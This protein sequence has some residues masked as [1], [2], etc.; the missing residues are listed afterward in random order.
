MPTARPGQTNLFLLVGGL[1]IL[2]LI[3]WRPASGVALL[4]AL[5]VAGLALAL[6]HDYWAIALPGWHPAR[7]AGLVLGCAALGIAAF[8][9]WPIAPIVPTAAVPVLALVLHRQRGRWSNT[10]DRL[11]G[12]PT[13]AA[14]AAR[15]AEELSRGLR[16]GRPA[17]VAVI[18]LDNANDILALHGRD[19][20]DRALRRVAETLHHH[21][22]GYDL[23]G[24]LDD[25]RFTLLLPETSQ[26]DATV[27]TERIRSAIGQ[28]QAVVGSGDS[29]PGTSLAASVGLAV[30]PRGGDSIRALV[31]RA[32][33]AIR[34]APSVFSA[35]GHAS[36]A[37]DQA[38]AREN[39]RAPQTPATPN[40]AIK[41]PVAVR[42]FI[43]PPWAV[44]SYIGLI[45]LI[46]S[47]LA[48]GTLTLAPHPHWPSYLTLLLVSV[49][50][51]N[52][53]ILLYGRGSISFQFVPLIA[54]SIL[55][56]P[57]YAFLLGAGAGAIVLSAKTF[58]W[59]A[60]AF[61]IAQFALITGA[62]ALCEPVIASLVPDQLSF[63]LELI[64]NGLSLGALCYVLNATI[65]IT[66]MSLHEGANPFSILRERFGWFLPY[67]LAFGLLA[68]FVAWAGR[69]F[70]PMGIVVFAIPAFMLH[71]VTKQY[72]DRTKENVTALREA[73]DRL[74]AMNRQLQASV[75]AV[76]HS[77]SATLSAF[78]GMLD[79]RDSETEGHSQRVVAYALAIGRALGLGS[80]DLAALEVGALLHDI[81]KVGVPDAILRKPGKLDPLE[82]EEMKRH[83]EIGY[84]LTSRIPFLDA[85]SP[86]VRH[87]HERW[88]GDG[89]PAGLR[90]EDIPLAARIFAVADA[91]DALVSDRPYRPGRSHA[92]AL[93]EI[94]RYAGT[95][96]DPQIVTTFLQI[97]TCTDWAV[98][99]IQSNAGN[100]IPVS[101][102]TAR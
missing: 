84:Q 9:A 10:I 85:A 78:S 54:A 60:Y 28:I 63:H 11:T 74:A 16:F 23:L 8:L 42:R 64:L 89:Y 46:T 25:T 93:E 4:V 1:V 65:L 73:H 68:V 43:A 92:Q 79:A 14:F 58:R 70:G 53:R 50:A 29:G 66:V 91:Y 33:D 67:T 95:Q 99:A 31:N 32:D 71:L 82:W 24:R 38:R 41:A 98:Q 76:E 72:V 36:S 75:E 69:E 18:A 90:G 21:S 77:Y 94:R 83:P 7:R 61:D 30:H 27:V 56:G 47:A 59:Q 100:T 48:I 101:Q 55:F 3:A 6:A 2:F 12:L 17:V 26:D 102:L 37:P 96:F 15:G 5:T 57:T 22:R 86:L 81:G 45:W 40:A 97:T 80:R 52:S 19:A 49:V 35:N 34:I 20:L 44:T 13:A 88:D 62:L 51:R 39:G 87:H